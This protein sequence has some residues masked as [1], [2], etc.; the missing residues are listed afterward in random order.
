P[1][2]RDVVEKLSRGQVKEAM[3]KLDAQGRMHEILDRDERMASIAHEYM[4]QPE[5]TLVVSP[6][7]QSRMEINQ[8]IHY[9]MQDAGK[10][11]YREHEMTVL[12]ARQEITGADRQWATQYEPGDVVRYTRGSKTHGIEAGDCV[13]VEP[14][15]E[16]ENLVT[17]K[18]GNG[19]QVSYD[20][21]SSLCRTL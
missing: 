20:P 1:A 14:A 7:N 17:V 12:V 16:K 19:G 5:G 15:Y 13:G 18:P 10:I 21:P 9:A 11:P 4:K 2:L 8:T 6:D 3:E